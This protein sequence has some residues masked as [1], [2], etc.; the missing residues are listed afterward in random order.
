M[1]GV[2]EPSVVNWVMICIWRLFNGVTCVDREFMTQ[3]VEYVDLVNVF[4]EIATVVYYLPGLDGS[5]SS[6]HQPKGTC[7]ESSHQTDVFDLLCHC[8]TQ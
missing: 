7:K 6:A 8:V 2:F 4:L 1:H 5:C 3:L